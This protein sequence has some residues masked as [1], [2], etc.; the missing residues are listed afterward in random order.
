MIRCEIPVVFAFGDLFFGFTSL[1]LL[2]R[3]LSFL[4][5][6]LTWVMPTVLRMRGPSCN[7]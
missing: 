1:F 6:F 4:I 5:V 3:F 7:K 2:G